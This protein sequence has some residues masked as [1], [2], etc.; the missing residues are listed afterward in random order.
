MN[1][2]RIHNQ[3]PAVEKW[4]RWVFQTHD[5]REVLSKEARGGTQLARIIVQRGRF[6]GRKLKEAFYSGKGSWS[7]DSDMHVPFIVM[8]WD[9]FANSETG[10]I[11]EIL[12]DDEGSEDED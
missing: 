5:L 9:T 7:G 8:R 12:A 10:Y 4:L 1:F 11:A 3:L 2:T 6:R